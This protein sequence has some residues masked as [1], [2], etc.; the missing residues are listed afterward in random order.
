M[1]YKNKALKYAEKYGI[2]D[3]EIK[4]NLMIYYVNYSLENRKY[5]CT[6][7]LNTMKETRKQI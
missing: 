6:V 3:Y 7:N 5:K 2:I 4:E 1:D